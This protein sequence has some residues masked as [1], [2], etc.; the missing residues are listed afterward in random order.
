M[1]IY[2][3]KCYLKTQTSPFLCVRTTGFSYQPLSST[4]IFY[5]DNIH[6]TRSHEFN[7]LFQQKIALDIKGK[8]Y[9]G[10]QKFIW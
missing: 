10:K 4:S 6:K 9:K 1:Y 2:I 7:S 3:L 5:T 8:G